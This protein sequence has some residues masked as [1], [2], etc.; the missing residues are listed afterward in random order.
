L[1]HCRHCG[2]HEARILVLER[3]EVIRDAAWTFIRWALP[4]LVATSAVIIAT[5]RS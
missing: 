2:N 1:E 4:I 5:I 3:R